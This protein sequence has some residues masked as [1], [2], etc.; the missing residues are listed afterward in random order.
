MQ[1]KS[2][3]SE[4]APETRRTVS[5][6]TLRDP[7]P[8]WRRV[9]TWGIRS[10]I[11]LAVVLYGIRYY[12]RSQQPPEVEVVEISPQPIS[13]V[14][15]ATGRVRPDQTVTVYAK[16]AGQILKLLRDEG[17]SVKADEVL[18]VMDTGTAEAA[19]GQLL[20]AAEAQR[21]KL[22]QARRE[23][24]R[25]QTLSSARAAS[26]ELLERAQL[27][28]DEGEQELIRLKAA[29]TEARKRIADLT[30]RSPL[31][32]TILQRFVDPGQVVDLRSPI[33]EIATRDGIT[34]VEAEVDEAFGSDLAL[35][36]PGV[37]APAGSAE[38]W[39]GVVSF[40]SP[41]VDSS[42]G[43]R[44]IR[45]KLLE[46]PPKPWPPGL[47]VD[48][49]VIVEERKDALAVPRAS[50]LDP[51]SNPRVRVVEGNRVAERPVTIIDWPAKDIIVTSGLSAGDRVLLKPSATPAETV[52]RSKV[53]K[54]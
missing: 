1:M 8:L 29:E 42:S 39:K 40:V 6:I 24:D 5:P 43:G 34:E 54:R 7:V 50:L 22:V 15:V 26:P 14:L 20:A 31:D 41:R 17:D 46:T 49:N 19:L 38:R 18:V 52:V 36:L 21:S 51:E 23:R 9:M 27:A 32:G 10:A 11:V 45:V 25:Q 16:Q 4:S 12:Q 35:E 47:S 33:L 53:A 37:L 48:V 13:R 3:T 30:L 44:T 2:E 28:V